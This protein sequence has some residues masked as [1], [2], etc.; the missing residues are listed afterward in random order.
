MLLLVGLGNPGQKY[1]RNR[2]NAGMMA[3]DHIADHYRLAPPRQRF[4]G[5]CRDGL[6]AG[7]KLVCL[8]PATFMNLSGQ[9]VGDAMR[10][11]KLTPADIVVFHDELD[12]APGKLRVKTGGGNGGH[13]GLRSLDAHIGAEYRRVRMGIGHPGNR[14]LVTPYLLSDFTAEE[15]RDWLTDMLKAIA[16]CAEFLLRGEDDA[17]QSRVM[18]RMKPN[19]RL[20]LP[21]NDTQQ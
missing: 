10:F 3:V 12:L 2:H 21:A 20:P 16:V 11:Y 9:S 4:Q 18:A 15:I 8:K 13:N 1:A 7:E 19:P 5:V 14:D 6:I 17:F